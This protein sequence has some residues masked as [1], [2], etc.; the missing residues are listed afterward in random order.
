[1]SEHAVSPVTSAHITPRTI[2]VTLKE[3]VDLQTISNIVATIGG[4]Y[5]CR[6]CGLLG[7]D[8]QLSGDPGD[9]SEVAGLP[10]VK[11]VGV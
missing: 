5:G 8:L 6:T 1:M 11:S 3:N 10:G 4:R 9:F 7:F 2:K